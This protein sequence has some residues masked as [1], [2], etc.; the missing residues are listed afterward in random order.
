MILGLEGY[1]P[2]MLVDGSAMGRVD[3]VAVPVDPL[4]QSVMAGPSD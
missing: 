4:D 3:A 1:L 2:S